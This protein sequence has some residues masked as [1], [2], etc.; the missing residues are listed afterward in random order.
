MINLLVNWF[1]ASDSHRAAEYDFCLKQN[2]RN[3]F[4]NQVIIFHGRMTYNDFFKAM[5]MLPK[6]SVNIMANLDI[7]FDETIKLCEFIADNDAYCLTR[8]ARL[9]DGKIVDFKTRHPE[10]SAQWSQDAWI[11]RGR[12][13]VDAPFV[14]GAPGCDNRIARILEGRGYRVTNP[15][16]SI[17]AIHVHES[18]ERDRISRDAIRVKGDYIPVFPCEL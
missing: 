12:P 13:E 17:K 8:W 5:D 10:A 1:D 2:I 3:E 4:I 7:Y 16:L 6:N 11:F 18:D 15:C 9:S 14:L